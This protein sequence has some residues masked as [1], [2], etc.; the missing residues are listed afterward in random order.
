MKPLLKPALL[1]LISLSTLNPQLSTCLAQGS[2][3]PPGAPAPT[4]KTLDQLG[5]N[6]LQVSNL[7]SQIT[8]TLPQLE[9]RYAISN[10]STNLTLSGSYYLI[11][12]IVGGGPTNSTVDAINIRTNVHNITIDLNGFSIINTNGA[13]SSSP[14]GIRIDEATNIVVR[15]G[16]ISGFDRAIKCDGRFYGILVENVKALNCRRAGIEADGITG[17]ASQT[18]TV[19][20]C[21]VDGVNATGEG[22]SAAADGIVALSCTAVIDSC[23]VRD[24]TPAGA[25]TGTCINA[26]TATNTFINNNFMS[27][28]SVGLTVT[29]GGTRVYYR[30]NLTAGCGTAFNI[31]GGVDRGGNF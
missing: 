28:A 10:F 8:K 5:T 27:Q 26:V 17:D 3:T 29:G 24:I 14:A 16:Q 15:N 1:V 6:I 22:A 30:N 25:S 11:T 21:I 9:P 13:D 19:R 2:L 4:M 7:V 20:Q 23:V 12:N 18:I 31:T